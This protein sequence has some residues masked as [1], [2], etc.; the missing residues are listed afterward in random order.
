MRRQCHGY[1][2]DGCPEEFGTSTSD[3]LGCPDEDG[4]DL[5]TTSMTSS[6]SDRNFDNDSDGYDDDLDD[7]C[8]DDWILQR[9]WGAPTATGTVT[10]T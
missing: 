8:P 9:G 6:D 2:P 7:F 1:N 5:A 10:Q 4:D 3:R